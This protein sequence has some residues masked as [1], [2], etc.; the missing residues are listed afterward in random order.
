MDPPVTGVSLVTGVGTGVTPGVP[1]RR[2]NVV[3][4]TVPCMS[5]K[6]LLVGS[7]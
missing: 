7:Y 3:D 6:H 5:I 4:F 1:V 2:E